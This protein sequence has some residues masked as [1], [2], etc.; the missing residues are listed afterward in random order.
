MGGLRESAA[1]LMYLLSPVFTQE[2][3]PS[4]WPRGL[5]LFTLIMVNVLNNYD[6]FLSAYAT[7]PILNSFLTIS[8]QMLRHPD[9]TLCI[10]LTELTGEDR[11]SSRSWPQ[12][13]Y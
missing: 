10:H 9:D 3:F 13:Q 6:R 4:P 5:C 2:L 12:H 11:K 8:F 1:R 7:K